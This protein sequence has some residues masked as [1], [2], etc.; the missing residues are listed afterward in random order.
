MEHDPQQQD[1]KAQLRGLDAR[2]AHLKV[3]LQRADTPIMHEAQTELKELEDR[4]QAL[5]DQI[6]QNSGGGTAMG[7]ASL[8]DK[9]ILDLRQAIQVAAEK[10]SK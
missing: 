6:P 10:I 2:I 7:L 9:A 8:L 5:N 1:L 4:R 3:R